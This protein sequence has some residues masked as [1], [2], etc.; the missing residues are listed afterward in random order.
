M[1]QQWAVYMYRDGNTRRDAINAPQEYCWLA[2]DVV[3]AWAEDEVGWYRENDYR[4]DGAAESGWTV[5]DAERNLDLRVEV[6]PILVESGM[7]GY[8]PHWRR[9]EAL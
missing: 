9:W 6:A 5:C 1:E 7:E 2:R 4:V 3:I 8:S